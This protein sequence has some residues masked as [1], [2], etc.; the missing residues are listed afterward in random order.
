MQRSSNS[1]F[2]AYSES[3]PGHSDIQSV[4]AKEQ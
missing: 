1:F 4:E 2:K 3:E